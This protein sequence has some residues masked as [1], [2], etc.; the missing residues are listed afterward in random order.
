MRSETTSLRGGWLMQTR[1]RQMEVLGGM[2][3]RGHE[4]VM[5]VVW[6][7]RAPRPRYRPSDLSRAAPGLATHRRLDAVRG[8]GA[9]A[10]GLE[11]ATSGATGRVGRS[12]QS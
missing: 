7:F 3:L 8:T 5:Q 12:A 4:Q 9:G 2:T 10:T 11:P 1:L 6:A